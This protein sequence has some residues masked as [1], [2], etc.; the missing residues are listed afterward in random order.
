MPTLIADTVLPWKRYWVPWNGRV[1]SGWDGSGFVTKPEGLFGRSFNPD[2]QLIDA[3]LDRPFLVLSGQPGIGK[4]QEV[5]RL[6][7]RWSKLVPG[8]KLISLEARILGNDF[9]SI[10]S[11]TVADPAWKAGLRRGGRIRLLIDGVDEAT[12]RRVDLVTALIQ[13]LQNQPM[14]RIRVILVCRAAEWEAAQGIKFTELWNK[15]SSKGVVKMSDTDRTALPNRAVS[16]ETVWELC[17]LC[18]DDA[19]TAAEAC[20]LESKAFLHEVRHLH[21]EALAARPITLKML[22]E[23]FQAHH[24][25]RLTYYELYQRSILRMCLEV[26]EDRAKWVEPFPE[27]DQIYAA[28]CRLAACLTFG[29]KSVIVKV[30]QNASGSSNEL[31]CSEILGEDAVGT[32]PLQV[33]SKLLASVLDTPLFSCR[34]PNFGFELKTYAEFLAADYVKHCSVEQLRSIFCVRIHERELVAPHLAETAAWVAIVNEPW[35]LY[36]CAQDP[37]I[38][39]RVDVSAMAPHIKSLALGNYLKKASRE[40][41]FDH[42]GLDKFYKTF[43]HSGLANQLRPYIANVRYNPVVRRIAIEI[44]GECRLHPLESLLWQRAKAGDTCIRYIASSLRHIT[45]PNATKKLMAILQG[46]YPPS[47]FRD[48]AAMAIRVLVP[49]K[50]AVKDVLPY[51]S[52]AARKESLDTYHTACNYYLVEYLKKSDIA[53]SLR[54]LQQLSGAFDSL[55]SM[56]RFATRVFQEAIVHLDDPKIQKEAVALWIHCESHHLPLPSPIDSYEHLSAAEV[57]AKLGNWKFKLAKLIIESGRIA[58]PADAYAIVDLVGPNDVA[59]LL[60]ELKK[61]PKPTVPFWAAVSAGNLNWDNADVHRKAILTTYRDCSQFRAYMPTCEPGLDIV[62]TLGVL[63][64]RWR[65]QVR[66]QKAAVLGQR[67]KPLHRDDAIRQLLKA[68]WPAHREWLRI[69]DCIWRVE[70]DEKRTATSD[71]TDIKQ[72]LG[73]KAASAT[74]RRGLKSCARQFL[75]ENRDNR[76]P[77]NQATNTSRGAYFAIRLLFDDFQN[78]N[79]LASVVRTRWPDAN[80]KVLHVLSSKWS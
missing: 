57:E 18:E 30:D 3:I 27:K 69:C 37:E 26:N 68:N 44:A 7:A 80:G 76:R 53:P 60:S 34:G 74:T 63:K 48:L 12:T 45:G 17:P 73:W 1:H 8:E 23:E 16:K 77:A 25:F 32:T 22:L 33:T 41:A 28:A 66:Q 78:D 35:G 40:E 47:G 42:Q 4:T 39:L 79:Q 54:W 55:H 19:K 49:R 14:A 64:R 2:L 71:L 61:A 56:Y 31:R 51:L 29:R 38:L 67:G 6:K 43:N 65:R 10:R 5:E 58:K 72:S 20:G 13:A 36:L 9:T 21:V 59:W 11:A 52:K 50:L 75:L 62:K 24:T 46:K 15:P 70:K